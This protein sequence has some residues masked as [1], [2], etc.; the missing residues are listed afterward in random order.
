MCN[1]KQHFTLTLVKN[2][3]IFCQDSKT[4]KPIV[5][6]K[7]W[8]RVKIYECPLRRGDR[9]YLTYIIVW[10]VGKKRMKRGMASLELAKREAKAIAEQLADGHATTTEITQKELQYFRHCENLLNG[11]P[12]DRAIKVYI[13]SNP[14]EVKQVRVKELV[15]E[16]LKRNDADPNL[17]KE[18]KRTIRSHLTRFS[19]RMNRPVSVISPRDIDEYLDD[20]SYAPRTRHNH[21]SSL[22]VLFNYARRKGY[23]LEDKR[24]AAEK[25]EEIR[26]KRPDVEIYSPEQAET[27]LQLADPKLVPFIAIGLFS[28][29]RTAELCRLNW[30][31]IDWIGGNIRLD[32][33][34]T[35]TNQS[36]LVPLL[37]N[38]TEW[39][40]PYKHKKGN[41]MASMGT[42]EPTRFVSPWLA[43]SENPKLPAKWIDNGMR[44]SFASYYLAYTQD[45]ARTAL[46]CGHS[47]SMLLGT[48]KTVSLNGVSITQEVAKRY[49]EIRPKAVENVV[50]LRYAQSKKS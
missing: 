27:T 8:A 9:E 12:L 25:S 24:H 6:Q 36:R 34:I 42:K 47:V 39:L 19:E 32:R 17:S 40:A 15:E 1:I 5:I 45:A 3:K 44:H 49:F 14:K 37:P 35:K 48:Y 21:R 16:F 10:R 33:N 13:E 46:A 22:I 50:P 11:V 26:F 4:M 20:P 28:G 29:V 23:L 31:D 2:V 38:L 7:G 43:K 30:E 18:Q 41:I